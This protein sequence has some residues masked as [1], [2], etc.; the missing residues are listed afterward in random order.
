MKMK[1]EWAILLTVLPMTFMT[2]LDSSIVNVALPTMSRELGTTM[3]G[4][5]WVVTSYLITICATILLFGRLGDIVGKSKV[6]KIGI[7]VF[8]LGS[9]FCGLSNSLIMLILSRIIQAIGA[10]AAMATNQGIITET[11]P[12]TK[13]GR[14]L[15]MTGTAVALGTM[16]GPTLGGLIVS[17]A[18]WEYIFLINIPIGILVYIGVLKVLNF[19]KITE[20]VLFDIKGTFLFMISIIMLFTSINFGQ[21]IGYTNPIIMGAFVLSLV[22]L[23]IFIKVEQKIISPMLDINIFKNKLFSLSIF[24]GFTSFVSI[25]AINIILPFYYQDVLKLTPSSAGLMMTVSPIILAIVA[26]ISGHLS[27]KLG[28]E[29]ISCIGLSILTIGIFSLTI[30]NQYTSLI[31]VAIFVGLVSLGSGIFQSP[32]NS[33]IMSTVDKTK[34]GIAGSVNG[35]VRNL[36]TTTGIA[37]STSILY[38]RMSSKIGYKVSGYVEGR[39]D[40]FIYAMR[41]VFAGIGCI[42]LIGAI[43]TLIRVVNKRSKTLN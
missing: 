24:C 37:L 36:G 39:A 18:P 43:L 33:L 40:I 15:G 20:K 10:G 19:K 13:R 1:K 23:F 42:C 26:P 28:S 25:G 16:V 35:L 27:D 34:L 4:I 5:E 22:L 32:N 38:S 12:P 7:G 14:A 17:V 2:T 9:L 3:A 21:S 30:F 29:K 41:F 31:I 11:F 8:T 6:F